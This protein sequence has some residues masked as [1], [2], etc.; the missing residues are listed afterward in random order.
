MWR[1][2]GGIDLSGSVVTIHYAPE[3]VGHCWDALILTPPFIKWNLPQAEDI[4]FTPYKKPF[5]YGYYRRLKGHSTEFE[6]GIGPK[7]GH[8]ITLFGMLG[9]EAVHMH[10]DLRGW[11][12]GGDHG[13]TFRKC[14][15]EV[16]RYHGWDPNPL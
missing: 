3:L 16:C 9:H 1:S 7:I 13:P 8:L 2:I 14:W 5:E 12:N 10:L 11:N 4:L 6:I 15:R